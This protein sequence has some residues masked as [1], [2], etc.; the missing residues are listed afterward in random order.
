M[1]SIAKLQR[2]EQALQR[3]EPLWLRLKDD[4]C[5]YRYGGWDGWVGKYVA[6]LQTDPDHHGRR[7][8]M[9]VR[10]VELDEIAAVLTAP[11]STAEQ[12]NS[13]AGLPGVEDMPN[14]EYSAGY[15]YTSGPVGAVRHPIG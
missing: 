15:R 2:I 8:N 4:P 12:G 10:Y 5:V 6:L 14:Y 11:A 3:D 13:L 9:A 1:P 7:Y